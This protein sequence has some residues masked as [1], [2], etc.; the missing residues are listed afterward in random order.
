MLKGPSPILQ[1]HPSAVPIARSFDRSWREFFNLSCFGILLC[2]CL[3]KFLITISFFCGISL[4]LFFQCFNHVLNQSFDLCKWVAL[5]SLNGSIHAHRELSKSREMFCLCQF[6][7][8]LHHLQAPRLSVLQK[9]NLVE[10]IRKIR[11]PTCGL[12]NDFLCRGNRSQFLTSALCLRF[13]ILCFAQAFM[14]QV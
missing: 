5:T 2:I 9:G 6:S 3:G 7:Q 8:E 11:R 14:M 4:S 10:P 12:L 13:I 1:P